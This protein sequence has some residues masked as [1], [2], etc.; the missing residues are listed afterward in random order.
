MGFG[1]GVSISKPGSRSFDSIQ[2]EDFEEYALLVTMDFEQMHR[3]NTFD[4]VGS[5]PQTWRGPIV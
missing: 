3:L 5:K 2:S 1:Y 4:K